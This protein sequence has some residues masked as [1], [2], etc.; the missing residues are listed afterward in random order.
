M[1]HMRRVPV[2]ARTSRR[3]FNG[4][5]SKTHK[6]NLRQTLRGGIRL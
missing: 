3:A 1:A 2:N 6:M 4:R 5:A